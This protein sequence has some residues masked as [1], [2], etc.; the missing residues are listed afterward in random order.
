MDVD[1]PVKTLREKDHRV[2]SEHFDDDDFTEKSANT[3]GNVLMILN[4]C[5]IPWLRH[6]KFIGVGER[7][8]LLAVL[9]CADVPGN[10]YFE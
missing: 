2:C 9:K 5:Y 6:E 4:C 3:R 10:F 7:F 1:T 8:Y